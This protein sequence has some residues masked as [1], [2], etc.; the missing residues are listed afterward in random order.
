MWSATLVQ[1]CLKVLVLIGAGLHGQLYAQSTLPKAFHDSLWAVWSDPA[2]ADTARLQALRWFAMQGY[3]NSRPDSAFYFGQLIHEMAASKG[4]ERYMAI[5]WN[6]QGISYANRGENAKALVLY[7]KSLKIMEEIGDKPGMSNSYNNIGTLYSEQEDFSK[8]LE[9]QQRSLAIRE[10]IGDP[11]LIAVSLNNIGT[12]LADQGELE[13]ALDHHQRSLRMR[14]ELGDTRGVTHSKF[15]IA[16]VYDKLGEYATA[17]VHYQ[18]SLELGEEIGDKKIIIGCNTAI[19]GLENKRRAHRSALSWCT[20]GLEMAEQMDAL[21]FQKDACKCLYEAHKGLGNLSVSLA[22]L[23]R[24]QTLDQSLNMEETA[25]QLQQMEFQKVML[26]DSIAKA[27]ETRVQE[28]AHR[29]ELRVNQRTR[30]AL[31]GGAFLLLLVAGGFYSRW[32]YVRKA[33]A[34]LQVEKDRSENLLLNILPAEVAEELKAKGRSDARDF[35]MVSILFTDFKG[36]TELSS[37]LSA[38]ELVNEINTCFE[39]F[40]AIIGKYGVE[41][42]KTIGDAYMAA[43]GLPVPSQDSARNT[44]LAAL[45]LQAFISRRKAERDTQGLPAFQMRVGIHTGPVV[46]GIVGVKKFQYDIWGD[47]VNTASRMESSGEVGKVNIS[48]ITYELVKDDPAFTFT[49]RGLVS[50]KGKG[51]MEM[52]FVERSQD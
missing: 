46:A 11:Y 37:S 30:N 13:K 5:G 38:G 1:T 21:L 44:V 25:K 16:S 48:E 20:R 12:I 24:I 32:R 14:E 50:A 17:M 26:Q 2:Q 19:G 33:K 8:A 27:E 6:I 35:E 39:A 4:L 52:Y 15:N 31:A 28:E 18:S 47:T 40:D 42:I 29:E 10:E 23:E 49:A 51:E 45:E 34:V 7:M 36:F 9:Y 43:G 22:F 3:M 41:K